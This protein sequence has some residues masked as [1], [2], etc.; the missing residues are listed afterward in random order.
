[1]KIGVHG[2]E[3]NRQSVPFIRSIFGLLQKHK[4]DLYVSDKFS[5][6]LSAA[7]FRSFK[8]K[9]FSHG[10][11]LKKLHAFLSIGGDGTLLESV[12]YIG[13]YEIPILGINTGRLGFLATISQ[14][15]TEHALLKVFDSDF[16]LDKRAILKLES[17]KK[18]FG[19]LNF[20][21]NDFTLM[22]KGASSMITVHTFIDGAF[23]NSYW[24]DGII[25]ATPTGSTGYSLS[26]GGPLVFPRSG[27]FVITPVS[28]HN[29]TVRPIVVADT[30]AITFQVE[31]RI[32]KFLVTLD[33]RYAEIDDTVKLKVVKADFKANLIQL[34]GQHFFKTL[35]QK[36]NWG[37][38][39]RN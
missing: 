8:W 29:L 9:T 19:R 1:M 25:V 13:P 36:L 39:I 38:D 34:K 16:S 31:G 10:A 27:N 2:K 14:T 5:Q 26:C 20:A 3:F 32:K 18:I 37:L 12:T 22:K 6:L 21:L 4:V 15:E 33:S 23:L 17:N 11:S 7:A 24:S 35:R 30:S 28:P